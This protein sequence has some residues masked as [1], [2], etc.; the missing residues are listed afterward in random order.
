MRTHEINISEKLS[1]KK[2]SDSLGLTINRLRNDPEQ[3]HTGFVFLDNEDNKPILAHLSNRYRY[4]KSK[5]RGLGLL[6]LDFVT[7]RNAAII[8]AELRL[9]GLK[10]LDIG[11]I[12]GIT[13]EGGTKVEDGVIVLNPNVKG[14]SLT[15]STFVL[16][17]LEQ[18]AFNIIDRNSWRI[19]DEDTQWQ[20]EILKTLEPYLQ[21]DFH[22]LQTDNIGKVV[23]IRPEQIVGACGIYDY[24]P[25]NYDD[26]CKA[27]ESVL[28]ALDSI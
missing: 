24:T 5:L 28:E 3:K 25:I 4:E 27:A 8:I 10:E 22:K 11:T 17:I 6:W 12:Y 2:E 18:F 19:T 21:P 26:A 7:E 16:C 9:L 23:R 1:G 20:K 13:N 14:D 15:C